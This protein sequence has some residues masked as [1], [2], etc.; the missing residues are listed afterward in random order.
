MAGNEAANLE[1]AWNMKS[2]IAEVLALKHEP[3][4]IL[5]T[6]E[7]PGNAIQ[8]KEGKFG[9]VMAMLAA[10]VRGRQAVFDR[11]TFGC[12]GGGTGLGFGNQYRNF[13]GGEQGFCHFLSIGVT[14][15]EPG[16]RLAELAKPFIGKE[17]YDTI[18]HGEGFLRTPELV[19][20]FL[21]C[22][23]MTN[24]SSK[25]VVFRPLIQVDSEK[26]N[27]ATVVF[28]ADMDQLS[29]L[30]VL[31]GYGRECNESVIIP[32]AAGC[33]S[34]GIYPFREASR[35]RPRAVIGLV[36]ISARIQI[37][38]QLKDDVMSFAVPFTMFHEMEANIPGSF[39]E[40]NSWI[41]LMKLKTKEV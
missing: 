34:I 5:L 20:K 35:E 6:D 32:M 12:P 13:P 28:L 38:R 26:E 33:Q 31:A 41:E 25:Y 1:E 15:W 2:R 18:I 27:P 7:K 39:L 9:C 40:K 16:R 23:P 21:E 3:V 4:A 10:A 37:K 19:G 36:D 14:E 11:K 8:L 30:V 22:L 24:V 17:T 29:A